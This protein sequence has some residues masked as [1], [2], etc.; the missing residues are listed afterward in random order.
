MLISSSGHFRSKAARGRI[1]PAT[2]ADV[3]HPVVATVATSMKN[4]ER[5]VLC[6]DYSVRLQK[7]IPVWC[8]CFRSRTECVLF[9]LPWLL[10]RA[11]SGYQVSWC[12]SG[13]SIRGRASLELVSGRALPR[14]TPSKL[15]I[16]GRLRRSG[17]RRDEPQVATLGGRPPLNSLGKYL[18]SYCMSFSDTARAVLR[19]PSTIAA[20]QRGPPGTLRVLGSWFRCSKAL[21]E[22]AR[23]ATGSESGCFSAARPG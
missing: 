9:A 10:R 21:N 16:E 4:R 6:T 2:P 23:S 8:C 18:I 5:I 19:E 22:G 1:L 15:R 12:C 7:P 13:S 3:V 20:I 14:H 11:K 17:L